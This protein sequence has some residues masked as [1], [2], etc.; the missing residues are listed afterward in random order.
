MAR[1][2]PSNI[3]TQINGSNIRLAYLVKIQTSTSILLTDHSKNITFDSENYI[4]DG[5]LSMTDQIQ[6]NS[7]LEYSD[8]GLQLYNTTNSIK[9]IFLTND[10]VN[11]NAI[12]FCAFLDPSE[13]I[14]NA[15]EYFKGTVAAASV[16]DTTNG[17]IVDVQLANQF[18]NWDI[19]RG[20]K[21]TDQSQQNL[22][23]G[24][25]A[26][27]FAHLAKNDIKWRA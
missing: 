27:Q 17:I 20:R 24:D 1:N 25:K 19:V 13:T 12:I 9:N 14:I 15:F 7:D 16:S 21:F 4:A 10:Y 18:K 22:Y 2:L 3:V 8:I 26:M 5:S 6:E 11:K 23:P